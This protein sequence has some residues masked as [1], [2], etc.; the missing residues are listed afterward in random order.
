MS[1][2]LRWPPEV[3][4]FN[5]IPLTALRLTVTPAWFNLRWAKFRDPKYRF[6][7]SKEGRL[8]PASM[9]VPVIYLAVNKRTSFGELYG[10]DLA[11]ADQRSALHIVTK[12][13]LEERIFL[14][15]EA[16]FDVNVYDLTTEGSAKAIK[17]DLSTLYT[18]DVNHPR[19]F[20]Q[21]LHDH[22]A[23]FDGILYESR[24]SQ[25]RCLVLWRTYTSDLASVP[26]P[27]D[28]SLWDAAGYVPGSL[29]GTLALFAD[30]LL[31]VG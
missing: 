24:H 13:E 21:R 12:K 14:K 27:E 11:A 25:A 10:D 5:K 7:A 3:D 26:M 20:A 22:P 31:V 17:M 2:R 29:P 1:R 28:G 23:K 15:T 4:E 30:S 19:L 18:A 8:T 16:P 9:K 6:F